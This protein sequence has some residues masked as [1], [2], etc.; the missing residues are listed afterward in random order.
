[1]VIDVGRNW[2]SWH[3]QYDQPGSWLQRRLAVVQQHIRAT[4]DDRP[5]GEIRVVS[6]CAGQARD[7]LGVLADH[8]RSHDVV[9]RLVEL[10]RHNV[11]EARRSAAA[12]GLS[13][14]DIVEGDA[15]VTTVYAG[16]VPADLVLACGVFGNVSDRDIENTITELPGLCAPGATVVWTR[17]P[18]DEELLPQIDAWF[19]DAG[20][21]TVALETQDGSHFGVGVHRL[22]ANPPEFRTGVRLFTFLEDLDPAGLRPR[23][24]WPRLPGVLSDTD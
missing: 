16:A 20:F 14:L 1:M 6:M 13:A 17:Y 18:R 9:G 19:Q 15:S 8:P 10:D 22:V 7:L 23:R 24:A 11:E 5:P 3:D 21:A 12:L 4:L 2:V